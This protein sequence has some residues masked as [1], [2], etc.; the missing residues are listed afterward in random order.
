MRKILLSFVILFGCIFLLND[1]V[2]AEQYYIEEVIEVVETNTNTRAT[3]TKT[4]KKTSYFKNSSGTNLWSV[5]VTGTFTYNGSTSSCTSATV[6]A[7]SYNNNWK[8]STKSSSKSGNTASAT[9]TAKYYLD[10]SLISTHKNTVK[11]T[12][13]KNGNLS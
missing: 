13:D 8:I 10:G 11:L 3:S 9:A 12:C 1:I 4:A 5:T 2:D 6:S 7:A